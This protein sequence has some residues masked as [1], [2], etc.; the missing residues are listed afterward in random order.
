MF[1]IFDVEALRAFCLE[2]ERLFLALFLSSLDGGAG[3]FV[4]GPVGHLMAWRAIRSNFTDAAVEDSAA[5]HN[6]TTIG[7]LVF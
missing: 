6:N 7:T 5:F 1:G 3:R 2:L 4:R